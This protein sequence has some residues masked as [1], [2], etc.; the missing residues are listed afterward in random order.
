MG[1]GR[2][3][4]VSREEF[5]TLV[6]S[7][8]ATVRAL[9]KVTDKAAEL[10]TEVA[11]LRGRLR[12]VENEAMAANN[13]CERNEGRLGKLEHQVL[14][15]SVVER[16]FPPNDEDRFQLLCPEGHEPC[17][18][19][20]GRGSFGAGKRCDL[21]GVHAIGWR[22]CD[23]CAGKGHVPKLTPVL[24]QSSPDA[25]PPTKRKTCPTC[26][27]A[28]ATQW[29]ASLPPQPVPCTS[30]GGTGSVDVVPS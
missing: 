18:F 6:Q 25:E 23:N 13:R 22:S 4:R 20:E 10:E 15:P 19:C 30:C 3:N 1:W 12:A 29:K 17:G 26:Q 7:M 9:E 5:E 27:G 14:L 28:G 8:L 16:P 24:F 2:S 21:D 11:S